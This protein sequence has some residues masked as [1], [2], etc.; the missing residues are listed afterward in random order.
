MFPVSDS[1]SVATSILQLNGNITLDILNKQYKKLSLEYHPDKY[2]QEK[3]K[4]L[5]SEAMKCINEAY[6]YLLENIENN[7]CD[8]SQTI[9]DLKRYKLKDYSGEWHYKTNF[10]KSVI[11]SYDMRN[12]INVDQFKIIFERYNAKKTYNIF[13]SSR[14]G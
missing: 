3:G 14:S 4:I 7:K 11:T 13:T 5:Q 6:T 8:K 9:Y 12:K 2:N 10:I 1:Y